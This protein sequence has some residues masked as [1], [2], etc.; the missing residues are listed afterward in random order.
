MAET[1]PKQAFLDVLGSYF[2]DQT[3]DEGLAEIM[4]VSSRHENF[5]QEIV[6]AFKAAI[7]AAAH[8]DRAVLDAVRDRFLRERRD[9]SAAQE[10][11]REM[12][13]EYQRLYTER[14]SE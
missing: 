7:D 4:S 12:Y 10:F 13:A 8:G 3:R 14:V 1:S 11:L 6:A 2:G 5:H 9:D